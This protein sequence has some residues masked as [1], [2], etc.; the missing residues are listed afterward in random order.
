MLGWDSSVFDVDADAGIQSASVIC[1]ANCM[2]RRLAKPIDVGVGR[3]KNLRERWR[4]RKGVSIWVRNTPYVVLLLSSVLSVH[5]L[6]HMSLR[7]I[8]AGGGSAAE[9]VSSINCTAASSAQGT[10]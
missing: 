6:R 7:M 3:A 8:D 5:M 10:C 9:Y 1:G 2:S 4:D